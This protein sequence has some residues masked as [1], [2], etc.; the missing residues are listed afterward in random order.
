[1]TIITKT[2]K[3]LSF[4]VLFKTII[5]FPVPAVC[6]VFLFIFMALGLHQWIGVAY[7]RELT[8]IAIAGF[9]LSGGIH[10]MGEA[11]GIDRV[12]TIGV[13]VA[14]IVFLSVLVFIT[15]R[16]QEERYFILIL[17]TITLVFVA[18]FIARKS[19]D[20]SFWCF[21][22]HVGFG[23]VISFIAALIL[24]V[25]TSGALA[26]IGYLFDIKINAYIYLIFWYFAAFLLAPLYA[27][28]FVPS[29]FETKAQECHLPSQVGFIANWI[30]AP[31]VAVYIAI[32]Y[33]YFIKIGVTWDIPK[34]QLANMIAGFGVAGIVTYLIAWPFVYDGKA[35]ALLKG[36]MKYLF[37]LLLIP[38]LVMVYA[39]MIRIFDYGVTEKRYIVVVSALWLLLLI[40]GFIFKKLQLKHIVL[41]FAVLSFLS[42]VGPWGMTPLSQAS[43]F[44]RLEKTLTALEILKE[45]KIVKAEKDIPFEDRQNISSKLKYL[46]KTKYYDD[47]LTWLTDEQ[48]AAMKDDNVPDK[49][50]RVRQITN[51]MGFMF[52]TRYDNPR[53]DDVFHL[54]GTR[55]GQEMFSV[56]GYDYTVMSLNAYVRQDAEPREVV[57]EAKRGAPE[58]RW[59][60]NDKGLL[61]ITV[62]GRGSL[63]FDVA[64][65]AK[66][67]NGQAKQDLILEEF[68]SGM[69]IR[70]VFSR[71]SGK[72]KDEVYQVRNIH[73]AMLLD[74]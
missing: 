26:S 63:T 37:P 55:F 45:G 11:R 33:S 48:R 29:Y 15:D 67:K 19:D 25:G 66:E 6:C 51:S 16:G 46:N 20:L 60:I 52:V 43:Q 31:L 72:I 57:I 36:A 27:L 12:K 4:E 49:K 65:L 32:L 61:K 58:V 28:S 35:N 3:L 18:P 41:S 38:V 2:K 56:R 14:G 50:P 53:K 8:V 23:A 39:I 7:G 22:S 40:G 74:L 42:V 69:K 21:A 62:H 1:M 30:L 5:R 47:V 24:F 13:A 68:G 17:S 34:N 54:F 73:F 9:F 44:N 10:L 71:I 64:K 59:H 70:L